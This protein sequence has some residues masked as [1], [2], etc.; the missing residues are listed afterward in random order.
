[1]DEWVFMVCGD[2]GEN[3][4]IGISPLDKDATGSFGK[5]V[6][7]PSLSLQLELMSPE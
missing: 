7:D 4:L 2:P 5:S 3:Y 1:M 6:T